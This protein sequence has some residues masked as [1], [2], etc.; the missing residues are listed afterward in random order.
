[1]TGDEYPDVITG[2]KT[3]TGWAIALY[4]NPGLPSL[5]WQERPIGV[6][7]NNPDRFVIADLNSDKRNDVLVSEARW[8][9]KE[10]DARLYAFIQQ[11][12]GQF[13]ADTLLMQY[14]MNSLSVG[15]IDGDN[16]QDFVVGEHKSPFLRLIWA[17]NNGKG[18]FTFHEIDRGKE[19][20][21][22]CLLTDIDRDG[23][24][25]ITSAG[26]DNHAYVHVWHNQRN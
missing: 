13:I 17:E 20:H 1:L 26:W 6:C 19:H 23:D 21:I 5:A 10:P 24:L 11:P 7:G 9:G 12:S 15:D 18:Q 25:D 2:Q 22:G 8:P 16:D 4:A 14:S 3:P